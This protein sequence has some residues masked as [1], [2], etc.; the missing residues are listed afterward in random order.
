MRR[1]FWQKDELKI[2]ERVLPP[3]VEPGKGDRRYLEGVTYVLPKDLPESS[4]V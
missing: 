2:S 3:V 4:D 1:H